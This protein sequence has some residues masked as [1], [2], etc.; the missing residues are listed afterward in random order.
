M[1]FYEKWD[2]KRKVINCS[3]NV[4]G[5]K[6]VLTGWVPRISKMGY[7]SFAECAAYPISGI[8]AKKQ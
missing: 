4:W 7:T 2:M 6:N 3:F 8:R 5:E 1:R